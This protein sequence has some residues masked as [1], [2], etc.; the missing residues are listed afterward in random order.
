[1]PSQQ[2]ILILDANQ[3]SA[4]AVTRSLGKI[5]NLNIICSDTTQ[6][7]LAGSSTYCKTY[8]PSPCPHKNPFQFM[9]WLLNNITKH[10]ITC[11]FPVTEITSQLIL[12]NHHKL[13]NCLLPFA[14]IETIIRLADKA[15]LTQLAETLGI[16]YPK[17]QHLENI[18]QLTSIQTIQYPCVIKPNLS[19]IWQQTHWLSTRVNI[20]QEPEDIKNLRSKP[21]L[22]NFPFMLQEFIPGHG[23]GVFAL[24]DHGKAIAFFTH[25]RLREKP[26]S[27]GVSVLSRSVEPDTTLINMSKKLL[28]SVKWHG[29]AMVEYRISE[30][31]TPYLMEVN[32]RFWGSLQLAIDSGVDFPKLLWDIT[33]H[34]KTNKIE[35][36]IIN[37]R[38]RWL[39][40]DLDGLYLY[41]RDNRY[42]RKE[43][44]TRIIEFLTP[45]IKT[46][47]EVNR[48]ED[49]GP[50]WFELKNYIKHFFNR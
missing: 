22:Q 50:A 6:S 16:P 18:Q 2:T 32:T 14:N 35:N 9:D 33:T 42:S 37:Q 10:N 8:I 3:R 44:L 17:T 29:V 38:L 34:K 40:G 25:E 48:L 43:K 20:V 49:L 21:Y 4:L 39:L 1:M 5:T 24:Y 26:P 19:H 11:L 46:R 28:D 47:H 30:N 45:H 31:G 27:G 23:A 36:Y 13:G 15:Q 41:L 7:A 12:M